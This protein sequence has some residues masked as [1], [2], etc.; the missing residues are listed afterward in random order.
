MFSYNG[1]KYSFE[2]LKQ[3]PIAPSIPTT[4]SLEA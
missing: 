4:P 2:Y 1:E 3:Y